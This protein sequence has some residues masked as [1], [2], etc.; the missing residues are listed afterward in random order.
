MEL[1][2]SLTVDSGK[3]EQ[4]LKN[5]EGKAQQ[6]GNKIQGIFK[7]TGKFVAGSIATMTAAILAGG[8]KLTNSIKKT[9]MEYNLMMENYM[10]DFST[11]LGNYEKATEKMTFLKEYAAKT[12]F[13][14]KDIA[15][16]QKTLLAFNVESGKSEKILKQLG[17][18]S[19]GNAQKFNSLS[20]AF[21]QMFSTG[22]LN[23]NDLLQIKYCLGM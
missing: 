15:E 1:L 3:F 21:G 13:E 12:P 16:A 6:S 19:L 7:G 8:V 2:V 11:L 14:M 4:G 22:K 18:V 17:D 10:A 20:L 5:A 23:G 9:G